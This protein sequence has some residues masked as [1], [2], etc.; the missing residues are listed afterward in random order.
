MNEH[1]RVE[2]TFEDA[3]ALSR[4]LNVQREEIWKIIRG[5][6]YSTRAELA[7]IVHQY[8]LGDLPR[9]GDGDGQ[10]TNQ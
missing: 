8:F 2:A 6:T 4:E 10:A 3:C 7:M 1:R 5:V 9:A